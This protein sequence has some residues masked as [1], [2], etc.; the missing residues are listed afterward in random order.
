M[1]GK[2]VQ[3]VR[4]AEHLC[5]FPRRIVILL[6]RLK[7]CAVSGVNDEVSSFAEQRLRRS[8]QAFHNF[9]IIAKLTDS[10]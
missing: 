3:T 2:F 9:N 4:A 5:R 7:R 1:I 6:R 10:G 8:T